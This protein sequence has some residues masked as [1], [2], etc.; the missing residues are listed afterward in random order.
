MYRLLVK[1]K[2]SL[3]IVQRHA[4]KA[5]GF[6]GGGSSVHCTEMN[7]QSNT[8]HAFHSKETAT[9]THYIGGWVGPRRYLSAL[10]KREV[11]FLCL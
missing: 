4:L 7:G 10:E 9:G 2:L 1:L 11:C 5:Y 3:Y 6:A 8:T